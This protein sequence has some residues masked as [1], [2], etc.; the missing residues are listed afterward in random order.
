MN[1]L[2]NWGDNGTTIRRNLGYLETSTTDIPEVATFRP[3][4]EFT[5]CIGVSLSIKKICAIQIIDVG[6]FW[7]GLC[8]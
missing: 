7:M 6:Q 1:T 2:Y 5:P 4:Y 8:K 3:Y